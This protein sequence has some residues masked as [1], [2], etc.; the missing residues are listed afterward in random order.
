MYD[1][2][3]NKTDSRNSQENQIELFVR[4]G[5]L[6]NCSMLGLCLGFR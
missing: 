6:N 5:C 2:K 1:W 3:K 4:K